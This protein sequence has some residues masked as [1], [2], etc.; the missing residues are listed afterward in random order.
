MEGL[1]ARPIPIIEGKHGRKIQE[2][3]VTGRKR[4]RGNET[5]KLFEPTM[6]CYLDCLVFCLEVV[7]FFFDD[8]VDFFV[9]ELFAFEVFR[10]LLAASVALLAPPAAF[11]FPNFFGEAPEGSL[12][13]F[14]GGFPD[15]DWLAR[16]A[17]KRATSEVSF[18]VNLANCLSTCAWIKF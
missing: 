14:F 15:F 3:I 8:L 17:F 10:F 9:E 4:Q 18:F 12:V 16:A 13:P 5:K 6:D 7:D 2:C 1:I 11:S